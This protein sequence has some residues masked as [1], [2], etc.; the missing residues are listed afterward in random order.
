MYSCVTMPTAC[1]S[2]GSIVATDHSHN[3]TYYSVS[4]DQLYAIR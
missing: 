4:G 3:V 2:R 1:M